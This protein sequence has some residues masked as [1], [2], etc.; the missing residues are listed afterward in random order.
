MQSKPLLLPVALLVLAAGAFFVPKLVEGG[1]GPQPVFENPEKGGQ[2]NPDEAVA[3]VGSRTG[4]R[5]PGK[6]TTEPRQRIVIQDIKP[7]L[8]DLPQGVHGTVVS[9]RGGPIADADVLLLKDMDMAT[10]LSRLATI[11][12]SG[13]KELEA[14]L[15]AQCR[16]DASGR[17]RLGAE[18]DAGNAGFQL[19]IR[20]ANHVDLTRKVFVEKG[21]WL[22]M[23]ILTLDPGRA[24]SGRVVAKD[25]GAPI[26][27]AKVEVTI[28][29]TSPT[30]FAMPGQG[31][32]RSVEANQAGFFQFDSILPLG[33]P[34]AFTA[35]AEGYARGSVQDIVLEE[36]DFARTIDIQLERG[37]PIRGF[38][39]DA[40]Q[41]PLARA[42]VVA[43]P[44][45]TDTP[46]PTEVFTDSDGAY[47]LRDVAEGQYTVEATRDGYAKNTR[48]PVKAGDEQV[49]LVLEKQAGIRVTVVD[50]QDK[51]VTSYRLQ[52]RRAFDDADAGTSYGQGTP[53]VDVRS[54]NGTHVLTAV[55]HGEW[56][57]MV[58]SPAF[59]RTYS[60]RF[61]V[62]E[63]PVDLVEVRVV[64]NVGGTLTG[65]VTD[66][67]GQPVAGVTVKTLD[68]SYQDNPLTGPGGI[69]ESFMVQSNADFKVP[70]DKDGRFRI[71]RLNPSVYQVRVEH[72]D[73][74]RGYVKDLRVEEGQL[75]DVGKIVIKKGCFVDGYVTKAGTP[76]PH[77]EVMISMQPTGDQPPTQ[78][79]FDKVF[80]D[81]KGYFKSSRPLPSG[82][83]TLQAT[84]AIVDNPFQKILQAQKS[85]KEA[86]L[87]PGAT[88][89]R[90]NLILP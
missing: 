77:A 32:S 69:F 6:T 13:G 80:T 52:L 74:S 27:G 22:D 73:Y 23:G 28:P 16:T 46:A 86:Q 71:A 7:D 82:K 38:V 78:Y 15:V 24:I 89:T 81:E 53:P 50:K 65:V 37:F 90:V 4:E 57:A 64:M 35:T 45:S 68:N 43:V 21:K 36:S 66:E 87:F 47:E 1:T 29:S 83:Y 56:A 40:M 17:F 33:L 59:A 49:N 88:P 5:D 9:S 76:V 18:P 20:G 25:T 11:A 79:V 30:A 84:S 75:T 67:A 48:T 51:P 85:Q 2:R 42:K 34:L 19:H 54:A 3:D 63:S 61:T 70:T 60:D 41:Q 14:D 72:P 58:E 39:F 8:K 62:P 55:E 26:G 31:Q 44:F 10:L 12:R